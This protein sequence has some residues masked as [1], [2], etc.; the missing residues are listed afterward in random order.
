MSFIVRV[1][2][3]IQI[4]TPKWIV[5]NLIAAL[6]KALSSK[7]MEQ[8]GRIKRSLSPQLL[9][10]IAR[11]S[12]LQI[13]TTHWKLRI[14]NWIVIR[15][16]SKVKW[17]DIKLIRLVEIEYHQFAVSQSL[18][19]ILIWALCFHNYAYEMYVISKSWKAFI[20]VPRT[21]ALRRMLIVKYIFVMTSN[22]CLRMHFYKC[23]MQCFS[24]MMLHCWRKDDLSM[25][26]TGF[27]TSSNYSGP[28]QIFRALL[29][30]RYLCHRSFGQTFC[31][32]IYAVKWNVDRANEI[33]KFHKA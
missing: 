9:T 3:W 29:F 25:A 27:G 26:S 20:Y 19:R 17:I 11:A 24:F 13:R 5:P 8:K 12:V 28:S 32:Y 2:T 15:N 18:V 4:A 30:L 21:C 10:Q 1:S 23:V 16:Q 31:T 6:R 14:V 22:K 7:N 33:N